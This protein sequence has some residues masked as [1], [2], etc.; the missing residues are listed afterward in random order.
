MRA[1]AL[2]VEVCLCNIS[3]RGVCAMT[4]SPPPR[5][6]YVEL[7]DIAIPMVG[8]VVWSGNRRF[9]ITVQEKIDLG[10][11]QA[12]QSNSPSTREP[13]RK[14]AA[15]RS[16]TP[17]EQEQHSRHAGRKIQFVFIG[18]AAAVAAALIGI[19]VY[20]YLAHAAEAVTTHLR[21]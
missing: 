1:G 2:P 8:K 15:A 13:A 5:G 17:A 3:G 11:L 19:L 18:A 4:A 20:T 9:G 14:F 16:L 6:T 21:A 12:G 10:R 7:T